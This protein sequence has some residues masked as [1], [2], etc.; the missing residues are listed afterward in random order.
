M[1]SIMRGQVYRSR[2]P[3]YVSGFDLPHKT[4]DF[5]PYIAN[6]VGVLINAQH[7]IVICVFTDKQDVREGQPT[8]LMGEAIENA[9]GRIGQQVADYYGFK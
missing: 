2:L 4:G 6:D 5:V 7:K 3:R 8:A 9:I 1:I